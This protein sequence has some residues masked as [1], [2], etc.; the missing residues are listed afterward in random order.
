M[1]GLLGRAREDRDLV[2]AFVFL[3]VDALRESARRQ[4]QQK[5]RQDLSLMS[6]IR[7]SSHNEL[8]G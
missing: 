7:Q 4:K 5:E 1:F 3:V 6:H 8:E 2:P